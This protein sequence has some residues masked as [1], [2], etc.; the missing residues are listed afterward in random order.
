MSISSLG[1]RKLEHL[2]VSSRVLEQNLHDSYQNNGEEQH[3][4]QSRNPNQILK[5]AEMCT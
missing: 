5:K 3:S 4:E 1:M 2:E